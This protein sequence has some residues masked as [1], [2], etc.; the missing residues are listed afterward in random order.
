M[1]KS[2]LFPI[3]HKMGNLRKIGP[4]LEKIFKLG[5]GQHKPSGKVLSLIAQ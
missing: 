2:Y 5:E 1:K 4:H 3:L